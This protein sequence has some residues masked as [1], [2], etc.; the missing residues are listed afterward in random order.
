MANKTTVNIDIKVEDKDLATLENTLKDLNI[1]FASADGAVGEL[2][3]SLDTVVGSLADVGM[4]AKVFNEI[5]SGANDAVGGLKKFEKGAKDAA[6][7]TAKVGKEA[8][9]FDDIGDRFNDMTKGVRKVIASMK[10]LK[11]A[12][13]ATGIGLLITGFASLVAYFK[14]SE[15][16]SRKLAIATESLGLIFNNI[17]EFLG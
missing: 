11:G 5:E 6:K 9:I 3:K 1:S 10:T 15:E 2:G 4:E 16:G 7:E 13:A 14:S 12:I 17:V 8:T